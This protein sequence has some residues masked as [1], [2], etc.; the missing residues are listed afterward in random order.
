M[1][2]C[3]SGMFRS[4]KK[5]VHAAVLVGVATMGIASEAF[6][7]YPKR[8]ISL[9]IPYGTGGATDISARAL[10]QTLSAQVPKPIVLVNRTGAGGVTG[11]ASVKAAS[12]NGY[13][14]LAARVGSHTVNPAMKSKLPYA[15]DDF[16]FAGVYEINPVVCAT[17]SDSGIDSIDQLIDMVKKTPGSVSY[18]SSGVGSMNQLAGAMVMDAFGVEEPLKNVV[19][20]PMRGGGAAATAV[21]TGT[22][23]FICTNSSS[24]AGFIKNGQMNPLFVTTKER[25]KGIKAPTAAELGHPELESLVGW[26]G[27][28]G[29]SSLDSRVVDAWAGWLKTATSDPLFIR[30]MENL[31]SVVVS[32]NPEESTNFVQNQY[33]TFKVL[34]DK[35]GMKVN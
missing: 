32:M 22:A 13:T 2:S 23:T 16:K 8:P 5:V 11:S 18:S 20:L 27:I 1:K 7:D 6:A 31:G 34:V 17:S 30:K 14:M 26:T 3:D 12:G 29:P 35:L 24:L 33:Q 25:V 10:S 28:A 19:H 21:L 15:L 9:V 4:S